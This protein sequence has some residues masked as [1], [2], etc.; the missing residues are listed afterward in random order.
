MIRR[1]TR[2]TC[3][4]RSPLSVLGAR[5]F[6]VRERS[7]DLAPTDCIYRSVYKQETTF[8]ELDQTRTAICPVT[9]TGAD[10]RRVHDACHQAAL[11]WN[12]AVDWLHAEWKR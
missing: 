2:S 4:H 6:S 8:V 7:S 9:L 5:P 3:L 10:Y 11:L 1:R 12:Q